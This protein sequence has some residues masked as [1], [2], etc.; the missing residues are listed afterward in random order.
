MYLALKHLHVTC[1]VLSIAGFM[2]RG[3]WMLSGSALLQARLARVLPHLVDSVLLLSALAMAS[4]IGQYPF[5]AT[6][7]TA[8]VVGLVVYILLGVVALRR[9]RTRGVRALAFFAALLAYAWIVSVA[10]TKSPAGFLAF[11]GAY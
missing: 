6:W 5:V 4:M 1:V 2:L 11:P 3:L 9:G 10:L 8:K 7:V